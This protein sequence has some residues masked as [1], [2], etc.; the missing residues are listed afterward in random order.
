[1]LS[2]QL[3]QFLFTFCKQR[4][5]FRINICI[6]QFIATIFK[7]F[8]KINHLG[9][10]SSFILL[11]QPFQNFFQVWIILCK[12]NQKFIWHCLFQ[13]FLQKISSHNGFSQFFPGRSNLNL[14]IKS[15]QVI[16]K[17]FANLQNPR[18]SSN[19][20]CVCPLCQI[21][22]IFNHFHH[23]FPWCKKIHR[24]KSVFPKK[25][26]N[27]FLQ[28]GETVIVGTNTF[29]HIEQGCIM[30]L[31]YPFPALFQSLLYLQLHKQRHPISQKIT[32]QCNIFLSVFQCF[33]ICLLQ[34]NLRFQKISL[35]KSCL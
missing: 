35:K 17:S 10:K 23:R 1:M 31:H 28:S 5:N 4:K 2:H 19:H 27:L 15:H 13:R 7:Y 12:R 11:A 32:A 20:F 29:K 3:N 33:C 34:L 21:N 18:T 24:R 6:F 14:Y 25:S 30:C 9:N 22:L 16:M 8:S 26:G